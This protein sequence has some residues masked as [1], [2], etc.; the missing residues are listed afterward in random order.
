MTPDDSRLEEALRSVG[1]DYLRRN[2]ADFQAVR[3]RVRRSQ[4]R[5]GWRNGALTALAGAA[6]VAVVVYAWPSQR[7]SN[8]G[9]PP[10]GPRVTSEVTI[11]V[12][13]GPSE[14]AVGSSAIWVSNTLDG[15][16][17]RIDPSTNEVAATIS[18]TGA[19]GDL[20][21]DGGAVWVANTGL[22]AVQRVDSVSN[23]RAPDVVIPVAEE[24]DALDL[25][26]DRYLWV[27]VVGK[28]LV[29]VDPTT[30]KVVR[31][32]TDVTP[33]NVAARAGRVF[34]L[35]DDGAV[36]ELDPITGE[37]TGFERTFD[38]SDRGDVH[39]YGGKL[40]VADGDGSVVYAADASDTSAA[41]DVYEFPGS[42]QEMVHLPT[43]VL[44]LSDSGSGGILSAVTAAGVR[45]FDGV[46][47][48][49]TRDLVLGAGSL[50]VSNDEAGTV[51]RLRVV[52]GAT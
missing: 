34:V 4:R 49:M 50:W 26:I 20:A 42:Y 37:R 46:E 52:T 18:V 43:E 25:A 44:V 9:L 22:G 45:T 23:A 14:V 11:E 32:I 51:T 33:V 3:A 13:A 35:E 6:A 29:Q 47:L 48:G 39:F 8:E 38:V 21:V 27:A 17:S 31:R 40:W 19:P 15:T 36:V 24:G 7:V 1:D 10:A 16:V 41:I 30:S 5:R 28:E 2:P 12:G